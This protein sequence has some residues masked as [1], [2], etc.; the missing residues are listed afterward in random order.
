MITELSQAQKDA[1]PKYVEKWINIGLNTKTDR[2]RA[3]VVIDDVYKEGGLP[4]PAEKVWCQSPKGIID[5]IAKERNLTT[6]EAWQQ[7]N[8]VY[9]AHDAGWLS[10][11]DYFRVECNLEVCNKL[12]PLMQMAECAGWFAPFEGICIM[13]DNPVECH[14]ILNE[15][16]HHILH[17]DGGPAV[18]YG[19]GYAVYSLNGTRVS[20]HIAET[21]AD[22]LD[23]VM[24]QTE[25]NADVRREI[26]RKI[27]IKR[28]IEKLGA[29]TIDTATIGGHDYELVLLSVRDVKRPYLKMS[30]PTTSEFYI[31][32]IKPGITTVKGALAWREGEDEEAY[33][34]PVA[35]T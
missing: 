31:E 13:S 35:R 23:P 12:L 24:I 28:T 22:V 2:E 32:G 11:Y 34:L 8:F 33:E 29:E 16:G 10:F 5:Y 4:P 6:K 30:D 3:T 19:D 17:K 26:I 7:T 25:E 15:R 21:P 1:M 9:G 18:R 14:T 27:G 20:Q